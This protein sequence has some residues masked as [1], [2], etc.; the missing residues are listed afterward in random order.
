M[1]TLNRDDMSLHATLLSDRARTIGFLRA[2][3]KVVRHGDVVVEIG[4]GT[5][6]LAMAAVRAGA[7]HVYAIEGGPIGKVAA[8]IIE[9]NEMANHIT[10]IRGWSTNV[11]LPEKGDVLIAELI[12]H[13]PFGERLLGLTADAAKRLMKPGAIA[14][15]AG[16]KVFALPVVLPKGERGKFLFDAAVVRNWESEFGFDLSPLT[17][18]PRRL[19]RHLFDPFQLRSWKFLSPS[20]LLFSVRCMDFH[21]E[22]LKT[23]RSAIA[24]RSGQLGGIAVY[25]ELELIRKGNH[26]LSS[27]PAVVG[28]DS[29]WL[30]PVWL[31]RDPISIRAGHR[32]SVSYGYRFASNATTCQ[33][34]VSGAPPARLGPRRAR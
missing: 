27:H 21:G 18:I 7:R 34:D 13:E 8:K 3:R 30:N 24:T 5:G 2:I 20:I 33:I 9:T 25:F 16:I 1:T 23:T 22:Q 17:T 31:L 6:L 10:L 29:N 12:G 26:K 4:T 14:I 11:R 32:L 15:P 19:E 28:R